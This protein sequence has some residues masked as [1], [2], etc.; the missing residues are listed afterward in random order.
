MCVVDH[1]K[2]WWMGT[3]HGIYPWDNTLVMRKFDGGSFGWVVT[4]FSLG[5][6]GRMYFVPS[7]IHGTV[8]MV[9]YV[10]VVYV[11]CYFCYMLFNTLLCMYIILLFW[12]WDLGYGSAHC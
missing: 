9:S 12:W 3:D 6:L 8:D 2:T 11:T 4:G 7:R 1:V 10:H 5:P